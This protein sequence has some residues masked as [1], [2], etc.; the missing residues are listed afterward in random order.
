[1]RMIFILTNTLLL[2]ENY[3]FLIFEENTIIF[4]SNI[5]DVY[6]LNYVLKNTQFLVEN[7]SIT[8]EE[9]NEH[10][11][12]SV[13][14]DIEQMKVFLTVILEKKEVRTWTNTQWETFYEKLGSAMTLLHHE[15]EYPIKKIEEKKRSLSH[16]NRN[17]PL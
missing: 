16:I 15:K 7:E 6:F 12:I 11:L 2:L 9:S 17:F 5:N 14:D 8:Q 4:E 3:P 10:F 13:R 1:M